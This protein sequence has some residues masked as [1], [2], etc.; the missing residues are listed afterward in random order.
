MRAIWTGEIAFGLVTIPVRL[1][2]AA[3]DLTPHFTTL[4]REC[5]GRVHMAR[6]CSTCDRDV[7]FGELGK[8]YEVDKGVYALFTKE[9]LAKLEDD[10]VAGTI[11]IVA[12]VE[13]GEIDLSYI[14][15]SYWV[16]VGGKNSRGFALLQHVLTKTKRVAL[17]KTKLRSR[18]RLAVLRPHG[19]IF[20]L[21]RMRFT[22]EIVS[23]EAI[24]VPEPRPA[25]PQ[26]LK[27][28]H[29]LVQA[30]SGPFDPARHPDQYRAAV[31]AAVEGKTASCELTQEPVT[32]DRALLN[33]KVIDLAELLARSLAKTEQNG[34]RNRVVAQSEPETGAPRRAPAERRGGAKQS[35]ES[36]KR[37]TG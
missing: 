34:D 8:G 21:E 6:R 37:A 28:A 35:G 11:E 1:Y 26:E 7:D 13:P 17:A 31:A 32:A 15:K 2:T 10:E 14:D 9:E 12:F 16:G 19:K 25:S 4:H 33:G 27:L 23:P 18:T 5:G 22:D 24:D 29:G 36:K 30:L 3:R 20:A